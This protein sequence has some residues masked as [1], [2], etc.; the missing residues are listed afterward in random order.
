M[1]TQIIVRSLKRNLLLKY[2]YWVLR[3][4]LFINTWIKINQ[5]NYDEYCQKLSIN[6]YTLK[7]VIYTDFD[8]ISLYLPKS[9]INFFPL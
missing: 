9:Y 6:G 5:N 8:F 4:F 1:C 7:L 3:S 2:V